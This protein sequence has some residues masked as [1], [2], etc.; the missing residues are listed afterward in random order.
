MVPPILKI[1]ILFLFIFEINAQSNRKQFFRFS[2]SLQISGNI[3][4][5][6]GISARKNPYSFSLNGSP[7]IGIGKLNLLSHFN[8][9]QSQFDYQVSNPYQRFG[10]TPSY[11]WFKLHLG[12]CSLD[13]SPYVLS[14][15]TF[16][17]GGF[18]L[19]PGR[20]YF[21]SF[22]G[23]FQNHFAYRDS[24][25][26]GIF[27]LPTGDRIS[28]GFKMGIGIK[29]FNFALSA[30]KSKDNNIKLPYK[31]LENPYDLSPKENLAVG[32]HIK[33]PIWKK[34]FFLANAGSSIMSRDINNR[35]LP[36][37]KNLKFA[38][39]YLF[40]PNISTYISFGGDASIN[41]QI[42]K[43]SIALKY[44][45]IEPFYQTLTTNY[46][47]SDAENL[48]L[49][50]SSILSSKV[51]FQL[52]GGVQRNNLR[53]L[54]K[55]TN[56]RFVGS[57]NL[58]Y[59]ISKSW[60]SILFY[61]NYQQYSSAL[62][63]LVLE[64]SDLASISHSGGMT[65][66]YKSYNQRNPF[67]L[68]FAIN[69]F[70]LEQHVSTE[71]IKSNQISSNISGTYLIMYLNLSLGAGVFYNRA[72]SQSVLQEQIGVQNSISLQFKKKFSIQLNGTY[73]N[74]DYQKLR[75]GYVFRVGNTINYR[76]S[77]KQ[78]IGLS[79][80]YLNHFAIL[81]KSFNEI[82]SNLVYTLNF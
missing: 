11:K 12:W 18:E 24:F 45:R 63:N 65:I 26:L 34:A 27:E 74:K 59:N 47:Q 53:H 78:G 70:N 61:S 48:T 31:D 39:K 35:L 7:N 28:Y 58:M 40:T 32:L 14:G 66:R 50:I 13:Y 56:N 69:S 54:L 22:Y 49:N 72:I 20:F 25:L 80:S 73:I 79:S 2:G 81:S 64:G 16:F 51:R 6:K 4:Q 3:Y 44:Q 60:N 57:C 46:L 15:R 82:Q 37:E 29:K 8:Y 42:R 41:M 36:I 55:M 43:S 5:S 23:K 68:S 75:N 9:Q 67:T 76:F 10:V 52:S 30:T 21:S 62:I 38:E 19:K 1:F 77:T 33:I 17:G 71:S